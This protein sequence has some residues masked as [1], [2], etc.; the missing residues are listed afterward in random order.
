MILLQTPVPEIPPLPP[1]PPI[2][3]IPGF[4]VPPEVIPAW[5][6]FVAAL[7]II[8]VGIILWP[9]VRALARRIEGRSG[10]TEMR[11]ELDALHQRLAELEQVDG[12]LG[13]LENRI[14]FSERL[15]TQH[16]ESSLE[17]GG[18]A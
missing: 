18:R 14:E 16:R 12:R 5:V 13:E 1:L 8:M 11:A 15:L 7:G 4:Q 2:P 10:E 17:R 9:I 6:P 3:P